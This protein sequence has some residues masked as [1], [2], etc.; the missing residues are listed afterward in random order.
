MELKIEIYGDDINFYD[1]HTK[2]DVEF[3]QFSQSQKC[4]IIDRVK[5]AYNKLIIKTYR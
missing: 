5:R 1:T 4:E 3:D 2:K